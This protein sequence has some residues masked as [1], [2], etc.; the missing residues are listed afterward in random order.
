MLCSFHINGVI[1]YLIFRPILEFWCC[2]KKQM[3]QFENKKYYANWYLGEKIPLKK[4]KTK[5]IH[6]VWK[7]CMPRQKKETVTEFLKLNCKSAQM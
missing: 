2:E 7:S 6:T 4:W 1:F 3:I 5:N